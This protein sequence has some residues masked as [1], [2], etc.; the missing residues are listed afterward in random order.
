MQLGLRN[1]QG[2]YCRC[3]FICS[4]G[5]Y[6][7]IFYHKCPHWLSLLPSNLARQSER[8]ILQAWSEPNGLIWARLVF[9]T[10]G[11]IVFGGHHRQIARCC[12]MQTP[13]QFSEWQRS[14]SPR[15]QAGDWFLRPSCLPFPL[16]FKAQFR[17]LCDVLTGEPRITPLKDASVQNI[18]QKRIGSVLPFESSVCCCSGH[19]LVVMSHRD[20]ANVWQPNI[21]LQPH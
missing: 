8:C 2:T 3:I 14:C 10:S 20:E 16:C 9:G 5:L 17:E 6:G 1:I 19:V 4:G 21:W 11:M 13:C 15:Y 7:D 12:H 18:L